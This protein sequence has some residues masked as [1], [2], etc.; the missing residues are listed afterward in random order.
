MSDSRL[1]VP[2]PPRCLARLAACVVA[3]AVGGCA[4]A[5]PQVEAPAPQPTTPPVVALPPPVEPP[6]PPAPPPAPSPQER[7]D[8]ATRRILAYQEQL[9]PLAGAELAAEIGRLNNQLPANQGAGWPATALE[10]AL[11]LAQSRNPGDLARAI[12]LVDPVVRSVAPDFQ[13]WQPIARLISARL[14]EQ[15][16]LEEQIERQTQQLRESQRNVQQLNEKLE[17]LK[18]IERSLTNRAPPPP[19][20]P[21][22]PATAPRAP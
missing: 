5:P 8:A 17:A 11:A 22:S 4:L 1:V 3:A 13:P 20:A 2:A 10:L 19:A 6:P 7:A 9:R 18:A 15:R 16:R 12:S 14:T 21:A